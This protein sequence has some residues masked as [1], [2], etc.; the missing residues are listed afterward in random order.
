VAGKS[1]PRREIGIIANGAGNSGMSIIVGNAALQLIAGIG[2]IV[3]VLNANISIVLVV[4]AVCVID[5]FVR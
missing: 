1:N 5:N 4:A 2:R 3:T